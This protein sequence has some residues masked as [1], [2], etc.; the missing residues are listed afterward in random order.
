MSWFGPFAGN[1]FTPKTRYACFLVFLRVT[2]QFADFVL[3]SGLFLF[4]C[5]AFFVVCFPGLFWAMDRACSGLYG[6]EAVLMYSVAT[7]SLCDGPTLLLGLQ[8]T[9]FL[10]LLARF[11]SHLLVQVYFW[12][13]YFEYLFM[14]FLVALNPCFSCLWLCN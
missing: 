11:S 2:L 7:V 8:C 6:R 3:L 4:G 9:H 10:Y 14:A 12:W 1:V 5:I 13:Y